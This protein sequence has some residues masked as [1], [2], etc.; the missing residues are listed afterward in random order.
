MAGIDDWDKVA[1][2]ALHK[3]GT[4][5]P[6]ALVEEVGVEQFNKGMAR[7]WLNDA[8]G[9][10]LVRRADTSLFAITKKGHARIGHPPP[11]DDQ[12]ESA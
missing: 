11:V 8:L 4:A 1:L 6:D 7:A 5:S 9:R 3:L 12:D 2:S 10:R